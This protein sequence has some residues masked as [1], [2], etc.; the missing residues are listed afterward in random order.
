[1]LNNMS[2]V[3]QQQ[4]QLCDFHVGSTLPLGM[5]TPHQMGYRAVARPLWQGATCTWDDVHRPTQLPRVAARYLIMTLRCAASMQLSALRNQPGLVKVL[6][7]R[8]S[9]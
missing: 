1:M 8:L 4:S 6:V 3:S 7:N 5:A 2:T 9:T